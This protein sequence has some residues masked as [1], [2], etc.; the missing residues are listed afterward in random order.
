MHSYITRTFYSTLKLSGVF[1][2]RFQPCLIW[3][4][5]LGFPLPTMQGVISAA[6]IPH[7]PDLFHAPH[8]IPN[9]GRTYLPFYARGRVV[10]GRFQF[11]TCLEARLVTRDWELESTLGS[12]LSLACYLFNLPL[13]ARN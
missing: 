3:P 4:N 11:R 9:S 12:L 10:G 2:P 13:P 8:C 6:L 1:T 5:S 7:S